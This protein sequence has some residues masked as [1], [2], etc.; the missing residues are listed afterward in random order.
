M[1]YLGIHRL[2]SRNISFPVTNFLSRGKSLVPAWQAPFLLYICLFWA[3]CMLLCFLPCAFVS[4]LVL[5]PPTSYNCLFLHLRIANNKHYI[6]FLNFSPPSLSMLVYHPRQLG[7]PPPCV[8]PPD[9]FNKLFLIVL[10]HACVVVL[11]IWIC[12]L[13][14]SRLPYGPLHYVWSMISGCPWNVSSTISD[15][16][17]HYHA[18]TH[19]FVEHELLNY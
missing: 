1:H 10:T 4:I 15:H 11:L 12:Q 18:I 2:L 8:K 6:E 13:L 9:S 5:S 19:T 14:S 17:L 16:I 7:E 3:H